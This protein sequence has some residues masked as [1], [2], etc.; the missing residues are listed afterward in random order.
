VPWG[1]IQPYKSFLTTLNFGLI[2]VTLCPQV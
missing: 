2:A 1:R